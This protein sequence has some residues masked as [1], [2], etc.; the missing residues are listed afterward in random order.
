MHMFFRGKRR[1][2]RQK[3]YLPI[4]MMMFLENE[5]MVDTIYKLDLSGLTFDKDM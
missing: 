5:K 3:V 1:G 4:Y 2:Q